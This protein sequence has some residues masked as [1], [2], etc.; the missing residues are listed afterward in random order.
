MSPAKF[1]NA[2]HVMLI[3]INALNAF[4]ISIFRVIINVLLNAMMDSERMIKIFARLAMSKIV[5]LVMLTEPNAKLAAR[6]FS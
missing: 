2:K 3:S 6:T 5:K 4:R 1:R